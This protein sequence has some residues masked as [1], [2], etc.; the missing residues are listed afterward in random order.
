VSYWFEYTSTA[1]F[2]SGDLL[3]APAPNGDP[4][5]AF[6]FDQGTSWIEAGGSGPFRLK[7]EASVTSTTPEPATCLLLIA[8]FGAMWIV[9]RRKS[10]KSLL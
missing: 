8:A 3:P 5:A 1:D 7:I 9:K 6:S 4:D 2:F 10:G